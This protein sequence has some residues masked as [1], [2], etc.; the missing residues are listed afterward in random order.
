MTK[1]SYICSAGLEN[2]GTSSG[3]LVCRQRHVLLDDHI[4]QLLKE[5]HTDQPITT[6]GQLRIKTPDDDPSTTAWMRLDAT[7]NGR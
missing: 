2:L 5:R 4:E 1:I 6:V 3:L 7:T